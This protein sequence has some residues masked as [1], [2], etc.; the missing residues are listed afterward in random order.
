MAGALLDFG[1]LMYHNGRMMADQESG[2]FFYLSKVES[3]LEARLW[4]DMFTWTES[5][6]GLPFGMYKRQMPLFE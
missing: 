1:V 3:A 2:P 4:D 5:Q 6:L